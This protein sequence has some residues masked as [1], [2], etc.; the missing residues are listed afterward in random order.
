MRMLSVREAFQMLKERGIALNKQELRKWLNN[1]YIVA[2]PPINRRVGWQISEEA[3]N[4]FIDKYENGHF[5]ELKRRRQSQLEQKPYGLG[6][7]T[8]RRASHEAAPDSYVRSLE[9]DMML[10]QQQLYSLRR[11]INDL[12]KVLGFPILINAE[13]AWDSN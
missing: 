5:E 11:E 4:E 3:L 6:E 10:L 2:V 1:G 8:T 12:K 7:G 13:D 9:Q